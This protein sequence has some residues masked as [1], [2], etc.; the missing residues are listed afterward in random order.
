MT[1]AATAS[2]G[3]LSCVGI[4]S[5]ALESY[6]I[7]EIDGHEMVGI[8][9]GPTVIGSG[10]FENNPARW[11]QLSPYT[12]GKTA[13]SE[14]E[15]REVMGRAGNTDAPADHPVTLVSWNDA[16]EYLKKRGGSLGLATEAEWE[17][18][19]RGP[20]VNMR[21]AMEAEGVAPADFAEMAGSYESFVFGVNGQ[22]FTDPRDESF[23]HLV[24]QGLPF[25]GWR[26][27]LSGCLIDQYGTA[28]MPV[29]WGPKGP[30]GTYGM[31][32]GV[33]EWVKDLC[34]PGG[35]YTS[36]THPYGVLRGVSW[37][38]DIPVLL[39][40]AYRYLGHT[41]HRYDGIGFRVSSPVLSER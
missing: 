18:A 9:G 14:S 38:D 30:Y 35:P 1:Y 24:K 20:A 16:Q 19:R 22:I 21:E 34:L 31:T 41:R 29:N 37:C 2:F 27:I 28:P 33:L 8:P 25:F 7:T 23:R 39:Y 5:S 6:P 3:A 40:G 26:R 13:V 4:T 10:E 36:G 11:V 12:I 15:Y 17:N 32:Y